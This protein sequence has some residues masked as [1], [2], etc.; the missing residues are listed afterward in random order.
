MRRVVWRSRSDDGRTGIEDARAERRRP[1][2]R[3]KG[4]ALV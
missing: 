4:L 2:S 3:D 1:V